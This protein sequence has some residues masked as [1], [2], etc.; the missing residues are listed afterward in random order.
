MMEGVRVRPQTLVDARDHVLLSTPPGIEAGRA[1]HR[2]IA[3][4]QEF[5]GRVRGKPVRRIGLK[6]NSEVDPQLGWRNRISA[7]MDPVEDAVM[8]LHYGD[9][10]PIE[11][12]ERA[13]AI[14]GASLALAQD[15][16]RDRARDLAANEGIESYLWNDS[17]IDG[18]IGRIANL[19]EPGCPNP[20]DILSDHN[21]SHADECPRCSR[22]VR[23]I[24]GG[25]ISPSDLVPPKTLDVPSEV[26]IGAIILH[27]DARRIRRK[28]ERALGGAAVRVAPD[29][30]LMSKQELTDAGP[31]LRGLVN[32]GFLPRHHIR[33]AVVRGPGRWSGQVLL[34]PT[35]IEAIES[36]RSR[37]WSEVDGLGE[38]PPP[39]PAPP[40]ATRWWIVAMVFSVLAAL[41]GYQ[42]LGPQQL[43]PDV[44]IEASFLRAEEG[45]EITFDLADLSVLDIV[46]VTAEGPAIIHH[47]VRETR[48]QWATGGGNYRVYV[49]EKTVVLIATEGGISD[50][51]SL[52]QASRSQPIPM[53]FLQTQIQSA[54]PTVAWVGSPAITTNETAAVPSGSE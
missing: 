2:A 21:R 47:N 20:L 32:D 10:M 15:R 12:V 19:A 35:A 40:K 54:H 18:M 28:L 9:G 7:D 6:A 42:T 11:E 29:V 17:R 33:G 5:L 52:I 13:A 53:E 3:L 37:P 30:W 1:E 49:P 39:R 22:A 25:V 43:D 50:L 44:P 34:G 16:L 27:P 26:V 51:P 24:R 14:D 8:R 36:A 31:A 38:L 46:G 23:L 4:T 48:G 41:V 45:W